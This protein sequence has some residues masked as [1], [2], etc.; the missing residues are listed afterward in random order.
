MTDKNNAITARPV[1][2]KATGRPWRKGQSGNP[3]G[4]PP[5]GQTWRDLI[6]E[7]GDMTG[8]QVADWLAVYSK[9][10]RKVGDVRLKPAIIA[11]AMLSQLHEPSGVLKVLMDR[12]EGMVPMP[13]QQTGDLNIRVEYVEGEEA[14]AALQPGRGEE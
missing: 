5:K 9:E 14:E 3:R 4:R 2:R 1:K 6:S 12:E 13:V 11:R 7:I 8:A 10:F